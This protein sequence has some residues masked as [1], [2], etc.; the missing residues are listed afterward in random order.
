VVVCG[1]EGDLLFK[2]EQAREEAHGFVVDCLCL[3]SLML[4]G[5]CVCG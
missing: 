2:I 4:E 5:A 1:I 3:R